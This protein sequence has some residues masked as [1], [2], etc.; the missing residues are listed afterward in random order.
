MG[1]TG[2][3]PFYNLMAI[4]SA[5]PSALVVLEPDDSEFT[6]VEVN[7]LFLNL[8]GMKRPDLAGRPFF[9]TLYNFTKEGSREVLQEIREDIQRT[10]SG[11]VVSV[12][13]ISEIAFLKNSS[14]SP[15]T[16]F[17]KFR[18]SPVLNES[19]K[20]DYIILVV[21]DVTDLLTGI[22]KEHSGVKRIR[23]RQELRDRN[24]DLAI[25]AAVNKAQYE[26]ASQELDDFVYS[27][28]HDLRAPLRRIDGFSQELLNEYT[29]R[30]DD[31]GV[32]YL[33]R[34]RQGAQ[35]MGNLIDDLLKLSRISRKKIEREEIDLAAISR[36][37]FDE[38][39]EVEPERKISLNVESDLN[40]NADGGLVKAMMTNLISNAIKF[41]S[42]IE[43]AKI[44]IGR[45]TIDGEHVFF[46]SDN[47]IG[48]DPAYSDK[49]FK[50]FSRLHSSKE[51]K[52]TGIGLATV[53]RIISLHGGDI[54]AKSKKGEGATFYFKL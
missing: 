46:I 42:G 53:K 14:S 26:S 32:H 22:D 6:V 20:I 15:K 3:L 13:D 9:S 27:V 7:D 41:S 8:T 11:K 10:L 17:L 40:L 50:A 31:T 18:C 49:L 28:S 19:G 21:E 23:S 25:Q 51:F 47:G 1:R 12:S 52:G 36:S 4:F 24:E 54:W 35:D 29:D 43:K 44:T 38:L 2:T 34:I 45:K 37:V 39:T 16:Y 30:L 33:N 48:F 5:L